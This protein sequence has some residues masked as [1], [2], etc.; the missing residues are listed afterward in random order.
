[1]VP[2]RVELQVALLRECDD[3]TV[4]GSGAYSIDK[5]SRVVGIRG[6]Q[7]QYKDFRSRHSFHHPTVAASTAWFRNNPYSEHYIYSR[8]ED[9][10]L[11][12][13]TTSTSRFITMEE[14]L[15]F[16]REAFSSF[17]AYLGTELVLLHILRE[18][19][20][21]PRFTYLWL[22]SKEM[23]KLWAACVLDSFG[24]LDLLFR[25]RYGKLDSN[26]REKAQQTLDQIGTVPLPSTL[27]P[28]TQGVAHGEHM[29][30]VA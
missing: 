19:F 2:R 28:A 27:A 9:A 13:R 26:R 1:M 10:E 18:H 24:R 25:Q 22:L 30:Y 21:T 6:V 8:A 23:G 12:C 4:V 14:P 16:Y 3:N 11:W 20:R 5:D 15:L 17:T 29:N 7:P